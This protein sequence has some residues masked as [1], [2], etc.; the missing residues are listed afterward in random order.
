MHSLT[1][2]LT[3]G[4]MS[5]IRRRL[6]TDQ[7]GVQLITPDYVDVDAAAAASNKLDDSK[8]LLKSCSAISRSKSNAKQLQQQQQQQQLLVEPSNSSGATA[9]SYPPSSTSA[10]LTP[11]TYKDPK[12]LNSTTQKMKMIGLLSKRIPTSQALKVTTRSLKPSKG[13]K[14]PKLDHITHHQHQHQHQQ[15]RPISHATSNSI[16]TTTAFTNNSDSLFLSIPGND[17][18]RENSRLSQLSDFSTCTESTSIN[19]NYRLVTD[20]HLM[21]GIRTADDDNYNINDNNNNNNYNNNHNH[22]NYHN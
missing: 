15:V 21:P 12:L 17:L 3:F 14:A 4:L 18:T 20:N 2:T 13:T 8:K 6:A 5:K 19:M 16:S 10:A 1:E 22:N 7:T 11:T 9:F